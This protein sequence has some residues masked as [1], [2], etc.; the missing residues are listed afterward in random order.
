MKVYG[1]IGFGKEEE[2]APGTWENIIEEKEV[3][4]DVISNGRRWGPDTSVNEDLTVTNRI[5]IVAS[6]FIYENL[7]AMK[8]LT[9]NGIKWKIRSAEIQRPRVILTLGDVYTDG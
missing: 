4:G 3:Y 5:S 6:R 9:W 8:Y 2:T 1:K 7:G